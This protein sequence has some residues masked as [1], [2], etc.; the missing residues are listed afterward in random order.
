ML[1]SSG[2]AR[3]RRR[4]S[5]SQRIKRSRRRT[6]HKRRGDT[7]G[8]VARSSAPRQY[9]HRQSKDTKQA[10]VEKELV[11][12]V[13]AQVEYQENV[14]EILASVEVMCVDDLS[15]NSYQIATHGLYTICKYFIDGNIWRGW[16]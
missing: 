14:P 4:Q 15:L 9:K 5:D 8:P 2:V 10:P 13:P 6:A 7:E 3:A 1:P 12:V 16:V 11:V